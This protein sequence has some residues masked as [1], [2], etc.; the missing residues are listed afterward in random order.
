MAFPA[1]HEECCFCGGNPKTVVGS[2]L[3][4]DRDAFGTD[5]WVSLG[6]LLVRC[7]EF[8]VGLGGLLVRCLL[9]FQSSEAER[10]LGDEVLELLHGFRQILG[11][12]VINDVG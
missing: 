4:T 2:H 12:V 1:I 10:I 11:D 6:S 3:K 5:F 9:I 8:W 7:T